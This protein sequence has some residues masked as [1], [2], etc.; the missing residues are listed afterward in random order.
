MKTMIPKTN[1]RTLEKD[2]GSSGSH[3]LHSLG[4]LLLSFVFSGSSLYP[5]ESN[6]LHETGNR[7]LNIL[8]KLETGKPV[9]HEEIRSSF[10]RAKPDLEDDEIIYFP[11]MPQIPE[12]EQ[13]KYDHSLPGPFYYRDNEGNNHVIISDC[14]IKEIHKRLTESMD[15]LKKNIESFR[16]SEDF[17]IMQDELKNWSENFRKDLEKFK[18]D[19]IKSE[20][21]TRSK[22]TILTVM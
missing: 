22:S 19:I 13:G 3:F 15:Q 8:E 10:D 14:D 20:K 6:S 1:Y 7:K 2:S 18:E 16:T 4:L 17:L 11:V 5:Q 21:Q 9:T 12:M